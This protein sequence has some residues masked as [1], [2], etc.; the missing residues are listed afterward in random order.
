MKRLTPIILI[1]LLPSLVFGS[2]QDWGVHADGG[3]LYFYDNTVGTDGVAET[4]ASEAIAVYKDNDTTELTTGASIDDDYDSQVGLHLI[5]IDTTQSGFDAGSRYTVVYTAGTVDSVSIDNRIIGTFRLGAIPANVTQFGGSNGTFA[6]GV[7]AV[8][9][10]QI[11]GDSGAA[12]NAE[13]HFDGTGTREIPEF[14][15]NGGRIWYVDDDDGTGDLGTFA[16]PLD[17]F[18]AAYSA[19]SAGDT[20]ILLPGTHTDNGG[21]TI[22]KHGLTIQGCGWESIFSATGTGTAAFEVAEANVTI[23]NLKISCA[24][25]VQNAIY[26]VTEP[27]NLLVEGT[28]QVGNA[29]STNIQDSD[30]VIVRR[31]LLQATWDGA[32][33]QACRN[34]IFEDNTISTDCTNGVA[35]EFTGLYAPASGVVRRNTVIVTKAANNAHNLTGVVDIDSGGALTNEDNSVIVT[36]SHASQTGAVRGWVF[37]D[38]TTNTRRYTINGGTIRT[39]SANG[40]ISPKDIA[41][42]DG[43]DFVSASTLVSAVAIGVNYNTSKVLGTVQKV[44]ADIADVLVDTG[45]TGVQIPAGEI[46]AAAIGTGAIDADAIAADAIGAS[47]VAAGAIASGTEAT[48]FGTAQTGDGYSILNSGVFGL[49]VIEGQTDDIAGLASAATVSPFLITK[50]HSWKFDRATQVVAP[51]L[52]T[53][54]SGFDDLLLEM[55]FTGALSGNASISSISS[56]TVTDESGKTEPTIVSS[57]LSADK[58]KVHIKTDGASASVLNTGYTYNVT[59]VTTDSQTIVRKGK[60]V[61]Q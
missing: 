5:T 3:T 15:S 4:P 60:L 51:N 48:G 7:P 28:W 32:G 50:D 19:A 22:A 16:A 34:T 41:C 11:S 57:S 52:I 26:G 1:L 58:K 30:N 59:I 55:D 8:N 54:V 36:A 13:L 61:V 47:E 10:T 37:Q 53:E 2:P 42:I 24:S 14:A 29:D 9:A 20:I 56:V 6:S 18:A 45:T 39:T 27:D 44:E 12:D 33:V 31:N 25:G 35:T 43:N 38:D 40:A 49:A 23:R 17:T 46:D 21:I